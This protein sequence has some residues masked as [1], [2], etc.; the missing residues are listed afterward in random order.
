VPAR[1]RRIGPDGT[2][3]NVAGPRAKYFPDLQAEDGLILPAAICVAP[4]GRL[5]IVDTG[6]NL[7]RILP[8]GA[9]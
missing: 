6:A 5:A 4:D 1:V 2:V 7:V 9:Y 3:H 8:A